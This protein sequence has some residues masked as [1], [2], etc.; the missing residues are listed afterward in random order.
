M[1]DEGLFIVSHALVGL[2]AKMVCDMEMRMV[3]I[4]K[5]GQ[6]VFGVT[7]SIYI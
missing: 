2:Y 7:V 5:I 6:Y 1:V 3:D 4:G